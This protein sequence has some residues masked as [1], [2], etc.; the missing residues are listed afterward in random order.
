LINNRSLEAGTSL[1]TVHISIVVIRVLS[2]SI[3]RR[4]RWRIS[5][6]LRLRSG[7]SLSLRSRSVL[8][9]R[10]FWLGSRLGLSRRVRLGRRVRDGYSS[11]L[12]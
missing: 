5:R 1:T 11:F 6:G 10:V 4:V 3:C 8:S 12:G 2:R 9:W 7:F